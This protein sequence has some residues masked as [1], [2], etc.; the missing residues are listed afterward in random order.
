MWF[1]TLLAVILED[2][3]PGSPALTFPSAFAR[4]GKLEVMGS[5]FWE[6]P[7]YMVA[8]LAQGPHSDVAVSQ[9]KRQSGERDDRES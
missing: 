4:I 2:G 1:M 3:S 6:K 8:S 9:V 7:P 5:A